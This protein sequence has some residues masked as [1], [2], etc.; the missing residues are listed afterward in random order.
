MEEDKVKNGPLVSVCIPAYNCRQYIAA[1][2]SSVLQQ[3]YGNIEVIVVND[4]SDDGTFSVLEDLKSDVVSILHQ[5]RSGASAARNT[6]Y[7]HARGTYIKF[8]DGDDLINPGMIESQLKLALENNNSI[9]SGKWGRFYGDDLDTFQLSPEP[10]WITLA[11]H[12]WLCLSWQD[13]SSM[14]QPGIFLIPRATIEKSGLWN[15][16]LSLIDDMDF[17]TRV[18]LQSD[19]VCFDP[20]AILYYRSGLRGSLSDQKSLQAIAS[21]FKAIQLSTKNLAEADPSPQ[22]RNACA[23]LWQSFAYDI[24]PGHQQLYQYARQQ[25]TFLGGST[26]PFRSGGLTRVLSAFLG[27]RAVKKIKY[28]LRSR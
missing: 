22:A 20:E 10:C 14:T 1:T 25:I 16:E 27:W 5:Q 2:I 19:L 3:S 9:I 7:R 26:L 8:L 24:Y 6:A 11:P 15:E 17:F 12:T 18:I 13:G 21:A 28:L 4:G 23:N